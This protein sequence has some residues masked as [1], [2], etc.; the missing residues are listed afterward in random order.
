MLISLALL[1]FWLGLRYGGFVCIVVCGLL[2]DCEFA[3]GGVWFALV[4]LCVCVLACC[5]AVVVCLVV[6]TFAFLLF[7]CFAC[8]LVIYCYLW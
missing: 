7:L 3:C 6:R 5:F 4:V 1:A 8:C 2:V